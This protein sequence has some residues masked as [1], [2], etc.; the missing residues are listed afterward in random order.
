[1]VYGSKYDFLFKVLIVGDSGS[2]KS[3]ILLRFS[4]NDFSESY[5]STIGLDFKIRT[6]TDPI[7][8]CVSK[9]QIWDTAG[10]ERFRTITSSYYRG[11]DGIL[12]VFDISSRS[13]FN[14]MEIWY[15]HIL[16]YSQR[17]IPMCLVGNKSDTAKRL[18]SQEDALEFAKKFGMEYIETSAKNNSNIQE[19][20]QNLEKQMIRDKK[21]QTIIETE[22]IRLELSM[23]KKWIGCC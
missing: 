14:H 1:M 10:Q 12:L 4:D 18:V 23:H 8:N 9:L 21:Q 20:F 19:C 15:S 6:L 13:S 11:S 17:K 2:G 16:K 7:T 5:L 22:S 3:S